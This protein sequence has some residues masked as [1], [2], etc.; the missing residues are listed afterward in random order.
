MKLSGAIHR[1]RHR[2]QRG[3]AVAEIMGV[4]LMLYVFLSGDSNPKKRSGDETS[5]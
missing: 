5:S 1:N 3:F 4:I 2:D